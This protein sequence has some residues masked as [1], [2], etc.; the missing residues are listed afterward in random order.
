MVLEKYNFCMATE[1]ESYQVSLPPQTLLLK[2]K[3]GK[4]MQAHQKK[5][6]LFWIM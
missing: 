4:K 2:D 1:S 6:V 5:R 3:R